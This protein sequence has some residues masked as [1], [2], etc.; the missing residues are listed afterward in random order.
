VHANEEE[1][2]R[3]ILNRQSGTPHPA[4]EAKM[5]I[6]R[7]YHF[8]YDSNPI[9]IENTRLTEKRTHSKPILQKTNGIL[10]IIEMHLIENK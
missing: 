4:P 10:A 6:T 1:L 3:L 2:C 5:K 9:A 7:N 8:F